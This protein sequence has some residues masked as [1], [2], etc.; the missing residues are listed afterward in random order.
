MQSLVKVRGY[1]SKN[2]LLTIQTIEEI[3]KNVSFQYQYH[4]QKFYLGFLP[5]APNFT[6]YFDN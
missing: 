4:Y 2:M 5:Y 3:Q 6:Y 1:I